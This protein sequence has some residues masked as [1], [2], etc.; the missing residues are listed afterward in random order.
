MTERTRNSCASTPAN[1]TAGTQEQPP[2]PWITP[3]EEVPEDLPTTRGTPFSASVTG[4]PSKPTNKPIS[5]ENILEHLPR[6]QAIFLQGMLAARKHPR[7]ESLD[8]TSRDTREPDREH[9]G[10]D[11][12]H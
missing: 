3:V 5:V 10:R 6:D 2:E 8:M 1:P 12:Q 4:E 9:L 11:H 7:T